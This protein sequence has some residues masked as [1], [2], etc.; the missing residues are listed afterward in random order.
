M[1]HLKASQRTTDRRWDYTN[2]NDR[3]THP[4]GYCAGWREYNEAERKRFC[5]ND[6]WY[7]EYTSNKDK[8]HEEG[9]ATEEEAKACYKAYQLD[10]SLRVSKDSSSQQ[11]CQVCQTWTQT[12]A[13]VGGYSYFVVCDEHANRTEIEKLYTVSESWES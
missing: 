12:R 13:V 10:T 11:K 6:K 7:D 9:H 3:R 5:M 4:I 1:N 2:T 8:Y